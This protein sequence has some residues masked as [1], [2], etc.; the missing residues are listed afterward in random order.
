MSFFFSPVWYHKYMM[1]VYYAT[2]VGQ[3]FKMVVLNKGKILY[4]P[5]MKT[6]THFHAHH[7]P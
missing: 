7:T 2:G 6:N 1:Y 3:Y 4:V 5:M